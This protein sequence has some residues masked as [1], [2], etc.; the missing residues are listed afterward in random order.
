MRIS[1]WNTEGRLSRVA[2][3]GKRGSPE[4]IV[5]EIEQLN[6]DIIFLPEAF[7]GAV[8][9]EEKIT[10]RLRRLGYEL[11]DVAYN[12]QG[13]KKYP[14]SIDTHMM[15]LSR[16]EILQAKELVLVGGIR[17]MLSVDVRDDE[18]GLPVRIFGIHLDDRVESGRLQQVEDLLPHIAASSELPTIALGDFNAMRRSSI[19][20]RFLRNDIL[21]TMIDIWPEGETKHTLQRITQMAIGKTMQRIERDSHL[22]HTDDRMRATITPKARGH[23]RRPSVRLMQIDYILVSP[24]IESSDFEV[25]KDGGADHRAISVTLKIAG[26]NS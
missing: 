24:A 18:S 3:A 6:S 14:V 16:L 17:S 10:E 12:D 19:A 8:P 13:E 1:S 5:K 22:R 7:D 21:E 2:E 9:V 25:A 11:F 26:Q 20:A 4:Q 15:I 23:E